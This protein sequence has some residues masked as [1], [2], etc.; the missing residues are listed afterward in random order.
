MDKGD[1][2][3]GEEHA[4]K[5]FGKRYS[6]RPDDRADIDRSAADDDDHRPSI[7]ASTATLREMDPLGLAFTRASSPRK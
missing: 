3:R 5:V 2:V 4:E 1:V 6:F 7:V